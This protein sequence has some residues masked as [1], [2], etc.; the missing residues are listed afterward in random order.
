MSSSYIGT[1][2][3]APLLTFL[4]LTFSWRWMFI[5]MGVAGLLVALIWYSVYREPREVS[6]SSEEKSYLREDEPLEE[7]HPVTFA[8]WR[9]LFRC[10]PTWGMIVG[11]F[12]VTYV[13]WVFNAWLP[14]YLEMEHHLDLKT[15]GWLTAI[16]FVF[17]I[18]G[19]VSAGF[20]IDALMAR[21]MSVIKSRQIPLCT[22]IIMN[23]LFVLAAAYAPSTGM[24][25]AAI[26]AAMFFN[27]ASVASAWG[28]ASVIAPASCT[29]SLG[30]MQNFGGYL[31]GALAPVITGFL[32]QSSGTFVIA[33]VVGAG[34]CIISAIAF[35]TVNKTIRAED[36]LSKEVTP[37][38]QR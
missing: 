35:A 18:G 7:A 2:L 11:Y 34:M 13:G 14:G 19:S 17:A 36:L 30:S 23:G 38:T 32:V 31:G 1:C 6:L 24:A 33:F 10:S 12:G 21:G 16:P 25:I 4:M 5:I 37:I 26:S 28:I 8:E 22:A 15:T 20:V 3:A 9:R 27:T 29:G